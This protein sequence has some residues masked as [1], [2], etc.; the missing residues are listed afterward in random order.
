[1]KL[2]RWQWLVC[3]AMFFFVQ[4]MPTPP[5]PAMRE[6][7][8]TGVQAMRTEVSFSGTSTLPDRACIETMLYENGEA[9]EWWPS[10]C[11]NLRDGLWD[12]RVYLDTPVRV[13][14][15]EATYT[16]RAWQRKEPSI[17]AIPFTFDMT[18]PPTPPPSSADPENAAMALLPDAA[19]L[20]EWMSQDLNGDALPEVIVLAG[21]GG[22]PDQLGYDF[23]DLVVATPDDGPEAI[24]GYTLVWRSGPLVGDRAESLH[25][26][27]INNDD[28]VEI[29]VKQALGAAGESLQI[30][31]PL[32]K[33]YMLLRPEGGY[34]DA[35]ESF[36]E[37][38]VRFEDVDGDNVP[39]ILAVYGPA[40]SKTDVYRWDGEAYVYVQTQ[41]L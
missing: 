35:R 37:T 31:A 40:A 41:E 21:F 9:L 39:E 24:A 3:L 28:Q 2:K 23:L 25:V 17:A 6:I 34:F 32:S 1:M 16:L 8:I 29:V 5:M 4:C 30:F 36:G 12:V 19:T 11:V 38:G 14:D 13:L 33:S 20:I 7:T 10:S 18:G 26:E 15:P 27:D 22:A